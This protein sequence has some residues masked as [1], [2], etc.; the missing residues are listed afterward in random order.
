MLLTLS[1]SVLPAPQAS[2]ASHKAESVDFNIAPGTEGWIDLG[3]VRKE[4]K[5]K[6]GRKW[7]VRG[8]RGVFERP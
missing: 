5:K 8:V 6:G 3:W 7:F 2:V 1:S 4:R